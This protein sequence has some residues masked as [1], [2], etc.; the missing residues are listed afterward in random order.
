MGTEAGGASSK[1]GRRT[2]QTGIAFARVW[3]HVDVAKED[4]TLGRLASAIATTLMGK[5]KPVYHPSMDCGD[6]V[7][8]TNCAQLQVTGNKL[9]Q[10]NYW[11]HSN[12]PGQLKL[13]PMENMAENKGYHE[14]LRRAVSGMLPKN[15]L[16][17]LR[18][19][20]LKAFD[21]SEHPYK[22]NFVGRWQDK[23]KIKKLLE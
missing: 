3:H 22:Q 10:K 19:D 8:V 13:T 20:R 12:K 18:L 6:Y 4:R 9:K 14:L 23:A 2:N 21:D 11:S 1:T 16:R 5:H 15:R 7:V 17:K